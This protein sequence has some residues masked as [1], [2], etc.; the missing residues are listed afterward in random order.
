MAEC[1]LQQAL[2]GRGIEVQSAGLQALQG[3]PIDTSA[4][5]VLVAQGFS[6]QQHIARQVDNS[7]LQW[8]DI[9]LV[10]ENAHKQAVLA[11]APESRGKVF[12]LGKWQQEREI[13]DPFRQDESVFAFSYQLIAEAVQAWQE[14]LVK[15]D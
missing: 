11:M 9:V 15:R 4:Q 1:L 12:L 7:H 6:W 3:Q 10:M 8:A 14:K 5:K 13:P 2:A